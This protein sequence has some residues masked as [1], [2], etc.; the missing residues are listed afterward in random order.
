MSRIKQ[1]ALAGLI[2]PFLGACALGPD[3]E[4]TRG[5]TPAGSAFDQALYQEYLALAQAEDDEGDIEDANYFNAK[6]VA[7]A[8]G[9]TVLPQPIEERDLPMMRR[10]FMFEVQNVRDM[11]VIALDDGAREM[12]PNHAARAQA[13]FDCWLQELEE[14][15]QPDHIKAC[16]DGFD[17]AMAAI[18]DAMMKAAMAQPT[19]PA[20]APEGPKQFVFFFEFDSAELSSAGMEKA[21]D[22]AAMDPDSVAITG[23]ADTSGA[24]AYNERLSQIRANVVAEAIAS[25]GISRDQITVTAKGEKM[26][27]RATGDGVKEQLNRR[28]T[29]VIE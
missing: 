15:N 7:A 4:M 9:G 28:V 6:A 18:D 19:A 23:H 3:L 13:M 12:V 16:R 29:V 22:I 26:P 8:G 21:R 27:A 10:G 5:M 25:S 20:P 17:E 11:L 14:N 24:A 2:V 1:L